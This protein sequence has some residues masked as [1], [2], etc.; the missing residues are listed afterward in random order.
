MGVLNVTPDSF[1]DGGLF[2]TLES[3]VAQAEKLISDGVDI[4]DIGG[5]STRP[6]ADS[7][8]VEEEISRVIPVIQ[9]IREHHATPISIDTTKSLVAQKALEAGANYINDISA[10]RLDPEMINIAKS[11]S[12]PVIIMHMQGSPADMQIKPTYKNIIQEMVAFFSERIAWLVSHG[13]AKNRI[14][15]DPGIGFGK[16]MSHNLTILKNL[17]TFTQFGVPLLLAHSRKR[18]LGDITGVVEEKNRDLAT[19]VVSALC[20]SKNIAMVRVH[21]VASTRQALEVAA[22]IEQGC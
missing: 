15:I 8:S 7:V 19:A 1:S 20:V 3:A 13:V 22:A 5:E 17:E 6:F 14:I 10:L 2:T 18:F 16:T 12:V 4:L 11:S 21:D 9:A